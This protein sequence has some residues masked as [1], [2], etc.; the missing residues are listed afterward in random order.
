[1]ILE[2]LKWNILK[3]KEPFEIKIKVKRPNMHFKVAKYRLDTN[4]VGG[5]I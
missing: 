3:S 1:M 5:S 2:V 4:H